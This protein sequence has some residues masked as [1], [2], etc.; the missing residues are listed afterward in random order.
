VNVADVLVTYFH[1]LKLGSLKPES[2]LLCSPSVR[3]SVRPSV[4]AVSPSGNHDQI[5][6]VVK[7]TTFCLSW[8][9]LS[10]FRGGV[11]HV[12]GHSPCLC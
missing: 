6:V 5:L 3:P 2:E 11:C 8:G 12:T 4:L 10:L 7:A 9:V 1:G